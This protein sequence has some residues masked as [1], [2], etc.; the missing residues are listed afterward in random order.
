M[1]STSHPSAPRGLARFVS[2]RWGAALAVMVLAAG[3]TD[4]VAH[5]GLPQP[6]PLQAFECNQAQQSV[7]HFAH[8]AHAVRL[9]YLGHSLDGELGQDQ[10]LN[11][12][13]AV[14]ASTRLGMIPPTHVDYDDAHTV[15]LHGGAL[16]GVSCTLAHP[17]N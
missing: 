10:V 16:D 9:S 17:A 5:A 13:D 14:T 2:S 15:R 1:T 12:G 11:W 4:L 3:L 8:G 6:R 7:L